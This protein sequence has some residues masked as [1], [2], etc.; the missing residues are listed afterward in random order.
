MEEEVKETA[1]AEETEA[2]EETSESEENTADE[3]AE[4]VLEEPAEEADGKLQEAVERYQRLFAEFDNFRK[5]TDKEK[6]ARYDMGAKDVI[7]KI[8]PVLDNFELALKNVPDDKEASAFAEGM[9]MIHKQFVKVLEDLGVTPIEAVGKEFDPAFHNAVMHVD[10][11]E[12]GDNIVVEEF[13]KGY[14]YKEHVVRYSMVKV[15]N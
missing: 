2:A 1:E 15:A 6:A 4:E 11:E 7:E 14:M 5:R 12:A 10:D 3:A 8:L 9:E 13:Q